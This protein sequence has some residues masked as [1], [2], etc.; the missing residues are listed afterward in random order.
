MAQPSMAAGDG[1]D[2]WPL[3]LDPNMSKKRIG[4]Y[5]GVRVRERINVRVFYIKWDNMVWWDVGY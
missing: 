3:C 2:L 1:A 4:G 5:Y